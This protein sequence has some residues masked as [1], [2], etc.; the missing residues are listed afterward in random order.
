MTILLDRLN[1]T[2]S[3]LR[4]PEAETLIRETTAERPDAPYSLVQTVLRVGSDLETQLTEIKR[5]SS[6]PPRLSRQ[7][8]L[9][10]RSVRPG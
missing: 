10:W 7:S 4:D 1:K 2:E 9:S 8:E 6:A 3:Q 5:A